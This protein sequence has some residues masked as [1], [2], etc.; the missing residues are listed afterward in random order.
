MMSSDLQATAGF[1]LVV[2]G[3]EILSGK[4]QDRHFAQF[5]ALLG[6]RGRRLSWHWVLPDEPEVIIAHLRFSRER[7][8]VAF[9]CGGIGA[10]PDDHT[11][12]CAAAA[13]G[14]RLWRHPGAVAAIEARFGAE[15]YPHRILMADLPEGAELIPNPYNRIS[16]FSLGRHFFLPGFPEM[17]WPMAQWVLD[18]HFPGQPPRMEERSLWVVG[19]VES[20]LLPIMTELGQRFPGVKLFSLPCLGEVPRIELGFRGGAQVEEAYGVL[21]HLLDAEGVTYQ[22][23]DPRGTADEHLVSDP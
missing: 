6:Q 12:A 20:R 22:P 1:G 19:A 14:V 5:R 10:P 2:I 15:A 3:D 18:T 8:G 21:R 13:F 16:G 11:R 9:V 7:G 17:A 4:R 23:G